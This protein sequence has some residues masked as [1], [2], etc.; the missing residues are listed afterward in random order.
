VIAAELQPFRIFRTSGSQSTIRKNI[1]PYKVFILVAFLEEK[2]VTSQFVWQRNTK[3][4]TRFCI[5]TL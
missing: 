1:V 4:K 3:T 2:M 5:C